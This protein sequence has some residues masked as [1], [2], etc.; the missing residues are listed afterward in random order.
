MPP[1]PGS[2][3]MLAI[4]LSCSP[5]GATSCKPHTHHDVYSA[6]AVKSPSYASHLVGRRLNP[7][8]TCSR[9]PSRKRP[10]ISLLYWRGEGVIHGKNIIILIYG[11][12]AHSRHFDPFLIS[13]HRPFFNTSICIIIGFFNFFSRHTLLSITDLFFSIGTRHS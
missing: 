10:R 11:L 1:P 13:Q 5:G 6:S 7:D 9:R 2:A 3:L 12:I 4:F 8:E